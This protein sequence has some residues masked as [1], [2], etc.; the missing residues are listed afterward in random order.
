MLR[1]RS[2]WLS[3]PKPLTYHI[4]TCLTSDRNGTVCIP[5]I[6]VLHYW[7]ELAPEQV[8][9]AVSMLHQDGS[10]FLTSGGRYHNIGIPNCQGVWPEEL[11]EMGAG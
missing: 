7:F 4:R 8:D 10:R 1:H 9:A 11:G 2:S 5:L 6:L 3:P